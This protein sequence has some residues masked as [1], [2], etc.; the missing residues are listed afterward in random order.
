MEGFSSEGDEGSKGPTPRR[1]LGCWSR[2]PIAALPE[3]HMFG[4]GTRHASPMLAQTAP[5]S[6]GPLPHL[7]RVA[8]R[9][10]VL[11]APLHHLC[12]LHGQAVEHLGHLDLIAGDHLCAQGAGAMPKNE[13]LSSRLS[14]CH[15]LWLHDR[16]FAT[17]I[18][19]HRVNRHCAAA[20][21]ALPALGSPRTFAEYSTRSLGMILSALLAWRAARLSCAR[22]SAWG[23]WGRGRV[24]GRRACAS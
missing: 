13:Q 23:R 11:R 7:V 3:R 15:W 12:A 16:T 4:N 14:W 6:A 21:H 10:Q 18:Q 2:Q 1:A 19:S 5:V 8:R 22:G 17:P 20:H 9:V 24:S